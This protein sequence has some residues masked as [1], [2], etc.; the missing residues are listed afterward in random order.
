VLRSRIV[1]LGTVVLVG[2]CG[3]RKLILL[4]LVLG[5]L[6][7]VLLFSI[8]LLNEFESF[9]HLAWFREI[10][11]CCGRSGFVIVGFSEWLSLNCS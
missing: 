10:Q 9:F 8:L 4:I 5:A 11:I 7:C 6:G 3:L 1:G 2:A